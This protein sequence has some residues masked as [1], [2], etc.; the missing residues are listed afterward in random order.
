MKRNSIFS[1]LYVRY[2]IKRSVA[3]YLF[4]L[5]GMISFLYLTLSLEVDMTQHVTVNI[6]EN[7]ITLHRN[8]D[9]QSEIIYLYQDRNEQV[10]R[11]K[12][13]EI[14]A[15][16]DD[17]HLIV[18]NPDALSGIFSAEIVVGRQT[19]LERILIPQEGRE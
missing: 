4:L 6:E 14:V 19:L 13:E 18:L 8:H 7:V 11:I 3:F 9:L 17:L 5:L 2:L 1:K 12:I 16:N 15:E 10:Y